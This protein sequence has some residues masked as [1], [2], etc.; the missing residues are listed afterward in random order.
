LSENLV[1]LAKT[2][3]NNRN[4]NAASRKNE[5]DEQRESEHHSQS[6]INE[7]N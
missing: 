1:D 3:E 6:H 2:L 4:S 5:T 7:T